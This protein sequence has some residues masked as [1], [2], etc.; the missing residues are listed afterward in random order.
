MIATYH[1]ASSLTAPKEFLQMQQ[2]L[3]GLPRAGYTSAQQPAA[4]RKGHNSISSAIEL[5]LWLWVWFIL[6]GIKYF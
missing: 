1:S 4:D 6:L 2:D 5:F 3:A